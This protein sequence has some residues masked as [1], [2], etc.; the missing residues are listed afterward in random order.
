MSSL[1]SDEM[2]EILDAAGKLDDR[3]YEGWMEIIGDKAYQKLM[4]FFAKENFYDTYE[5][6]YFDSRTV[7][8]N[9]KKVLTGTDRV[10]LVIAAFDV[11]V[12]VGRAQKILEE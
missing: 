10:A 9:L 1:Y 11:G 2:E 7:D 6:E 12:M 4:E 3:L 8:K 5:D